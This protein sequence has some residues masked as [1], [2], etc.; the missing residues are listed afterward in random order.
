MTVPPELDLDSIRER[1]LS[2]RNARFEGPAP[3]RAA[4]AAVL[5]AGTDGTPEVLL[6]ERAQRP[7]DPW[8]GHMAFP[9]GHHEPGDPD[10]LATA[11]RET[12]EEVGLKLGG[13]HLL[14]ALDEHPAIARGEFTGMV[15]APFVFA[16]DGDP[17]LRPNYEVADTVWAPLV[18]MASGEL[19]A[20][21]E[22]HRG[23]QRLTFP[24]YDVGG[25]VVWGMTHRMLQGL[26][27]V[28]GMR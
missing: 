3:R 6:I 21:K 23:E 5:R 11:R 9:G 19:D 24:G 28:L 1:L 22:V 17:Q 16:V 8:S 15:I 27:R 10:L 12:H 14:A 13:G 2:Y 18:P 4:V 7:G 25:R 20:V 26:F